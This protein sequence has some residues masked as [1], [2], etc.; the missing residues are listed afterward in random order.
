VV[1]GAVHVRPLRRG[2]D[3][4]AT[5]DLAQ[6]AFGPASA[7]GNELRLA[8]AW[9]PVDG[10]RYFGAL[11]DGSLTGAALFHDMTQ[12]W[13][14]RAVPMAGVA[15]VTVAPEARGTG[16]GRTLMAAL[17][18]EIEA[19]GYPLS[20]LYPSTT[21]LYRSFGYEIAGGRYEVSVPSRSLR[22]LL[23]PEAGP[24]GPGGQGP[25][26]RAGPADAAQVMAVLGRCYAAA[27]ASG[28]VRHDLATT[29]HLLAEPD[30]YNYLGDDAFVCY[31]WSGA[32]H[33]I[34]VELAVA[35]TPAA[36][37]AV[38]SL[39][40]SHGSIADTVRAVASPADPIG[41]L[42]AEPDVRLRR[43]GE[44]M[45]RVIS[46]P[47][48]VAARGF[49]AAVRASVPL[50]LAD[51]RFPANTGNWRLTVGGGRGTLTRGA[52]DPGASPALQLGPRGL[53]A[54]YAGTP[55]TTLRMAGLAS[56]GDEG[57]DA[58]LDAAFAGTPYMLD[59]F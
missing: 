16:T 42:T 20:A 18:A 11:R 37:R 17:L 10:G 29:A 54:L 2:D 1:A 41:W 55:V 5:L 25:L 24:G 36:A 7:A 59:H 50:T 27:R 3:L 43:E 32:R 26:R 38:W 28:P 52:E 9:P 8:G 30:L 49:P 15:G 4:A 23:P 53:A 33:D 34:A 45:L 13:H 58:D 39:L 56:G 14:G 12:W 57:S 40:A 47:A 51:P 35:A 6:R 19:R 46:A 44:W 48:A 31:A 22:R 21:P